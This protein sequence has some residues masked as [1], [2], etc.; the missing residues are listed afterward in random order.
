VF[1]QGNDWA[2]PRPRRHIENTAD[3]STSI[4]TGYSVPTPLRL[5]HRELDQGLAFSESSKHSPPESSSRTPSSTQT[6]SLVPSRLRHSR[7]TPGKQTDCG[8]SPL[9]R[10]GPFIVI[11]CSKSHTDK[12]L[13]F[14]I[15]NSSIHLGAGVEEHPESLE[16][17]L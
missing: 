6:G 17:G 15:T 2:V 8:P 16:V 1:K 11:L 4:S 10:L 5:I 7:G 12:Q 14:F 3:E 9:F 13:I